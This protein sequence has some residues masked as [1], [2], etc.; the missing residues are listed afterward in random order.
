MV[1]RL[2]SK[3]GHPV[4][5]LNRGLY[6]TVKWTQPE[7]NG[8]ADITGYVIKYR[9]MLA[10]VGEYEYISVDGNTTNFQFTYQLN[11]MTSYQFAVAAVNDIGQGEFTE[12]TDYVRTWNGKHIC[13][14]ILSCQFYARKHDAVYVQLMSQ[15][16]RCD[17]ASSLNEAV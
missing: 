10:D 11:A 7:N 4:V 6:V 16:R 8:G 2:P 15:Q 13:D 17:N 5:T 12:L 14:Q 9:R 1:K 3:P